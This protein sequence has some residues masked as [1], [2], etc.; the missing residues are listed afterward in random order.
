MTKQFTKKGIEKLFMT[1]YPKGML[2]FENPK[3]CFATY[4]TDTNIPCKTIYAY[5]L[6][7]IASELKLATPQVISEMKKNAGY[8]N[9]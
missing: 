5:D 6:Y 2:F 1:L 8:R 9:Y 3:K 4:T 7:T